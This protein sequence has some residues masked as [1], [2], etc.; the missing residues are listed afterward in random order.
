MFNYNPVK[1]PKMA[2]S[3][4][5][6]TSVLQDTR[7]NMKKSRKWEVKKNVCYHQKVYWKPNIKGFLYSDLV[8]TLVLSYCIC[9]I[10]YQVHLSTPK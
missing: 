4:F 6:K 8:Q 2:E 9:D 10:E 5:L 1:E 7:Q 3:C